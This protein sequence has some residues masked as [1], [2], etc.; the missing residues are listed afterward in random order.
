MTI[1]RSSDG[2]FYDIPDEEAHKYEVPREKVKELLSK[3][4]GPPQGGGGPGGGGP[5]QQGPQGPQG[6]QPYA[7]VV[8]NVYAPGG[9]PHGGPGG[10]GGHGGPQ[11]G[12]PQGAPHEGGDVDPYWWWWNNWHN[13]WPNY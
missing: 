8:I 11:G 9:A 13:Y 12:P 4:G 5:G 2:K 1:L 3:A 7:P 10:P 6:G